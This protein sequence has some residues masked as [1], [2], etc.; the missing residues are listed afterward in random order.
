MG[1]KLYFSLAFVL[2]S[3]TAVLAQGGAIKGKLIDK[4]T[5]EG[6]PF[7]TVIAQSNGS[8]VAGGNTDINGEFIIKPL[9][10]GKYDLKAAYVGYQSAMT[11]GIVVATDKTTYVNIDLSP[12]S[13]ELK[14]VEIVHY[15]EPLIDPDTKSGGTITREEYQ[16]MASK[17][18]NSVAA[19]TAGVYQSDE[20]KA[21][22]MR[23]A[24]DAGT[25]YYVDGQK[26]VG[27]AG[28]PQQGVEQVSVITGGV[29]ASYGDATGG[30]ISIT[31]RGPQSEYFGGVEAISSQFLDKF[32][33][34]FLGFSIG[35][36]LVTKKDTANPGTKN[37]VLGFFISGETSYEKDPNPSAIG[38][39]KVNDDVL[40]N[41]EQNP[42]RPAAMG[43]GYIPNAEFVTQNQLTH[44]DARQNVSQKIFRL[45][46]KLDFKASPSVNFTLGG[47]IDY[48]NGHSV[49]YENALF[50]SA[51]NPQRIETTWRVY[52]KVTQKFGGSGLETKDA[53]EKSA[54]NIQNA[55]YTIQAGYSN[56]TKIV[57]DAVHQ[58]NLF[59]YGYYGDFHQYKVRAFT[60][61]AVK[62]NGQDV[63][64]QTGY[65]DSLL[66]YTPSGLN[67]LDANYTTAVY[68]YMGAQNIHTA[69]DVQNNLGLMNGD[70]PATIYSLWYGTGANISG[71]NHVEQTQ[72]TVKANFSADVFKNHAIQVGFEYDQRA[73]SQYYISASSLWT[74]MGQ[75]ANS[76][77]LQMDVN[78]PIY[79]PGGTY[80][81]V[82][83]NRA[84]DGTQ[85]QF[86]KS[87]R[88]SL[89]LSQ[90]DMTWID[91]N[92]YAPS[93]YNLKMFSA[94]D[95][96]NNGSAPYL[97][98][99]GYDYTGAK[100]TG[101]PTFDDFYTKKDA[102]GNFTREI[103]PFRPIYMAGYIQD[104][105]DFRDIKF[106]IGVRI[107]RYDA[108]QMM[109]KDK[110]SPIYDTRTAAEVGQL[111]ETRPS[112]VPADAVVYV[113][114]LFPSSGN[115]P[116]V[117]YRSG[118]VWY[119]RNGTLVQDPKTS[120][121]S[122]TTTI[123]W[124]VNPNQTQIQHF[125]SPSAFTSYVPQVNFMPRIA[126]AFPISEQANFFAHY[127]VLTQR[128]SQSGI[129]GDDPI[130][131]INP[132]DYLFLQTVQ[133]NILNNPSL[134][135]ER[136]TDYELGFTQVLSEKKN[137]SIT[138]S[139][140]YR[141]MRDM[142]Q[143]VKVNDAYPVSYMSWGN[144]D[145]GTVKGFTAAYDLRRV[146]GISLTASY[147]LQF[148]DGTGSGVQDGINL[149]S[150]GLPN[151]RTTIPL[152]F[153]QRHA[154]VLNVDYRF[155]SGANYHGPVST[156]GKGETSKT[157]KWLNN[158]GANLVARLGSG[159]PYSSQ[160]NAI[161]EA[162]TALGVASR[163]TLRGNVNGSRT[164]W[165]Y[166]L[167]LRIDKNIDLTWGGKKEGTA[168]KAA[169]LNIYLQVLNLLNTQNILS[170]YRYTG[171]ANDDG[172]V[173][174]AGAQ[175]LI[176]QSASQ[177]SFRD[178]YGIKVNNPS[179]YSIPRRI[180]LGL[181]LSF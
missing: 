66:T 180:R 129:N 141:E 8:V 135:P 172:Y 127:D 161:P 71:Y 74:L 103:A 90:D 108:N 58:D 150:S 84:N 124:L 28:V 151:L 48:S 142:I 170:V 25:S 10:P 117:G 31:T 26:V 173:N 62:Y 105:F 54:S 49:Y 86:D 63:Y 113:N 132:I 102:N 51:D 92:S 144:I 42:L 97:K 167:D 65:K 43:S 160:A 5:K 125:V 12:A 77:I 57:Q 7:A 59:D 149:V 47:S 19:T 85:K 155:G 88:T 40:R 79:L 138:L 99:F 104:K 6:I 123:P 179:N 89:G 11:T 44:I 174:D 116:V 145:F 87:L 171:N 130:N 122:G 94:D 20:G 33:Y 153:D 81:I 175:T 165:N 34:D 70:H 128:P 110:Y 98:Y 52:A 140:F 41:I 80:P 177:Q 157:I 53:K 107:D 112:N 50:N 9:N 3:V 136:T 4:N 22:N 143:I 114:T 163:T 36:P 119:D 32:G 61:G 91:V 120:L 147:T 154:I 75:L 158:M 133:G 69:S 16:A 39:Y 35:G 64:L 72:T 18:I 101:N 159:T 83:F 126:F 152:N 30:V 67:P 111:G 139:A 14:N 21:L 156:R 38:T 134:K 100:Q 17:D 121:S 95:L 164:P 148:A 37:S 131:R 169:G 60:P 106:N 181:L 73:Q 166:R 76:H 176:A 137:S 56:Y 96:L 1:R 45:S 68:N 23:G 15:K 27:S 24:R 29:P 2:L 178:L 168:K 82:E 115:Q 109:P 55:Y 118:D 13:V 78:H 146:N 162:Q 93:T 46:G